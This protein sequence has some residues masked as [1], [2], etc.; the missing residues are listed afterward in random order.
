MSTVRHKVQ[1]CNLGRAPLAV[2]PSAVWAVTLDGL[3]RSTSGARSFTAVSAAPSLA[4]LSGGA[5]GLW[6]ID[7]A[8]YARF[9]ADGV[10]WVTG[11]YV[12]AVEALTSA[13][14]GTGHAAS[15]NAVYTLAPSDR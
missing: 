2:T 7:T 8:G 3:S 15:C 4:L 6:G 9:S 5:R 11:D 14:D 12:G 13:P 1:T 10:P